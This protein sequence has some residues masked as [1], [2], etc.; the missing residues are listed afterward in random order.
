MSR[1]SPLVIL[2]FSVSYFNRTGL[3]S[4]NIFLWSVAQVNII[5]GLPRS[6]AEALLRLVHLSG[7]SC[8]ATCKISFLPFLSLSLIGVMDCAYYYYSVK[9]FWPELLALKHTAVFLDRDSLQPLDSGSMSVKS[10]FCCSSSPRASGSRVP[11]V[12]WHIPSDL[13]FSRLK[14][15]APLHC[16]AVAFVLSG[17][18]RAKY[19][20]LLQST[21]KHVP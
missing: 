9:G 2:V 7:I 6:I 18:R 20:V 15:S 3:L 1:T 17:Q 11:K 13:S 19:L 4:S 14:P 10:S 21:S 5:A 12:S 8:L 16:L